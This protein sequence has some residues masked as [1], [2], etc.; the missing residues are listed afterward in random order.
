MLRQLTSAPT[1]RDDLPGP[2]HSIKWKRGLREIL[3]AAL[4]HPQK[5]ESK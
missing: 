3:A 5:G 2:L 1:R 4:R